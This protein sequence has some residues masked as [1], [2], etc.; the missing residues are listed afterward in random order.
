MACCRDAEPPA[1]PSTAVRGWVCVQLQWELAEAEAEA[2]A[3]EKR[4]R[5]ALEAKAALQQ[6]AGELAQKVQD[7]RAQT[8]RTAGEVFATLQSK[9]PPPARHCKVWVINCMCACL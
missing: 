9:V 1:E 3:A 4:A 8:E 5:E 2:Q 6:S 7:V